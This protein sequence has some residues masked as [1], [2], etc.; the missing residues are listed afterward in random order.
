VVLN[1]LSPGITLPLP[2]AMTLAS[3]MFIVIQRAIMPL[4]YLVFYTVVAMASKKSLSA[5]LDHDASNSIRELQ[6]L[7]LHHN[8]S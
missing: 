4:R 6:E 3:Q 7:P 8:N 2:F 5:N 1:E